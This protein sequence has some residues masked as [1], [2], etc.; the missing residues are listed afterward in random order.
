METL[1]K[2][3]KKVYVYLFETIV[4]EKKT[5]SAHT[6]LTDL[7]STC[8]RSLQ[9]LLHTPKPEFSG[10]VLYHQGFDELELKNHPNY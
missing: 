3:G 8:P 5:Y 7:D 6:K 2:V 4:L 9:K 10:L 1:K